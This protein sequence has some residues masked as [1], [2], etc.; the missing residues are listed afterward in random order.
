MGGV[1]HG[2]ATNAEGYVWRDVGVRGRIADLECMLSRARS[3]AEGARRRYEDGAAKLRLFSSEDM[4]RQVLPVMDSIERSLQDDTGAGMREGVE[5]T[6]RQLRAMLHRNGVDV[7]HPQ[8]EMFDPRQHQTVAVVEAE[9]R[10]W[11]GRICAPEG[12]PPARSRA[13]ASNGRRIQGEEREATDTVNPTHG[14][15]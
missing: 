8:D 11:H 14:L 12:L 1:G 15:A 4:I 6:G 2:H 7:I 5:Q 9:G 3:D 10:G 13:E